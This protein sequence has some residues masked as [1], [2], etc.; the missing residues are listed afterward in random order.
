MVGGITGRA[1]YT[2]AMGSWGYGPIE[3]DSALDILQPMQAKF[4]HRGASL[5]HRY[6]RERPEQVTDRDGKKVMTRTGTDLVS[7]GLA[8]VVAA[9]GIPTPIDEDEGKRLV[10]LINKVAQTDEG[11]ESRT[12]RREALKK[13][14][15]Q[16]S[17]R[18][19]AKPRSSTFANAVIA[20]A[21]AKRR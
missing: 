1:V 21:K 16:V 12:K 19:L 7:Q 17:A 8:Y 13:L 14:A 9:I 15:A 11:Y 6:L 10:G 4:V 3:N 18:T 5:L 2:A 20:K